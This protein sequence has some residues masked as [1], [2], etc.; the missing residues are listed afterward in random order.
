M[1]FK[2]TLPQKQGSNKNYRHMDKKTFLFQQCSVGTFVHMPDH[3]TH[4]YYHIS[5][6]VGRISIKHEFGESN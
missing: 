6:T 4:V 3:P 2:M 1:Q 5:K